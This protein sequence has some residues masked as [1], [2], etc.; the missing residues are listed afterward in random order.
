MKHKHMKHASEDAPHRNRPHGKGPKPHGKGPGR[1]PRPKRLF[2][3]GELRLLVLAMIEDQPRHGYEIIKAIEERFEGSYVPSPGVIYPT[4]AWMDDMGYAKI[5]PD[6]NGR[7]RATI[8][9]EGIAFLNANRTAAEDLMKRK[10]LPGRGRLKAPREVMDA[11]D[12]LKSA[13]RQRME[14]DPN[15]EEIQQIIQ[16]L[17]EASNALKPNPSDA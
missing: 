2:D 17:T 16:T 6:E 8:A 10:P 9:P 4:L 1:E 11:M 5:A 7:K 12:A 15:A 13:L 3:Y 14:A